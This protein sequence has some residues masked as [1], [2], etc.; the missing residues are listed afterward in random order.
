MIHV[1]AW[2]KTSVGPHPAENRSLRECE[3]G[4]ALARYA[5]RAER[6]IHVNV[7][8]KQTVV[9]LEPEPLW[10]TSSPC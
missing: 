10:T 8:A 1:Y 2:L 6:V 7:V 4:R 5:R 3:S 9:Y